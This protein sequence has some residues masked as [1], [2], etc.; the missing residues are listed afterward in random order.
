MLVLTSTERGL[1]QIL[2]GVNGDNTRDGEISEKTTTGRSEFPS[3]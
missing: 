2:C 1:V 3:E